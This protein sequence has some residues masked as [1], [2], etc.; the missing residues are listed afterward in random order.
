M[1]VVRS[2]VAVGWV[3]ATQRLEPGFGRPDGYPELA[4]AA[5]TTGGAMAREPDREPE[6]LIELCRALGAQLA[7]GPK[8]PRISPRWQDDENGVCLA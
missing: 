5:G 6:E 4:R 7:V 8:A 2:R 1:I 3:C